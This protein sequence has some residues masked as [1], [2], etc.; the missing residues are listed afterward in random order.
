MYGNVVVVSPLCLILLL[1][2]S[3]C[4]ETSHLQ[5]TEKFVS[6]TVTQVQSET[7]FDLLHCSFM[8]F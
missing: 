1:G 6:T 4:D 2:S 3:T 8:K 5:R 7:F